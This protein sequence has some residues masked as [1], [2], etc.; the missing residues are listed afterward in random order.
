MKRTYYNPPPMMMMDTTTVPNSVRQPF[1]IEDPRANEIVPLSKDSCFTLL[2]TT[3]FVI[4]TIGGF[5]YIN[6]YMM[7]N[8]YNVVILGQ[9]GLMGPTPTDC[10]QYYCSNSVTLYVHNYA[11]YQAC[12]TINCQNVLCAGFDTNAPTFLPLSYYYSCFR[13]TDPN[14]MTFPPQLFIIFIVGCV[15]GCLFGLAVIISLLYGLFGCCCCGTAGINCGERIALFFNFICPSAKYY[16]FRERQDW[17]DC[18]VGFKCMLWT[19]IIVT[20]LI[21]LSLAAYI[22][23]AIY[24]AFLFLEYL[25]TYGMGLVF[26]SYIGN[27]HRNYLE[28]VAFEE[29]LDRLHRRK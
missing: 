9:T 8:L 10:S 20:I 26:L 23:L 17:E 3:I 27:L 15:A 4:S 24:Q 12:N 11:A 1:E 2:L 19:D 18:R 5:V 6:M 25:V 22:Y 28:L 16:A 21:G 14:N 29:R 13:K 7:F